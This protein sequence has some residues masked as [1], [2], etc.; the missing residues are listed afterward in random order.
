MDQHTNLAGADR[1]LRLLDLTTNVFEFRT[2]DDNIDRY[3][4]DLTKT[5]RGSLARHAGTLQRLNERGAGVFV[6]V[7]E[8]DGKGR[9]AEHIIRVRTVFVDLDGV[10]LAPV[11]SGYSPP[12]I[13]VETSPER[14]HCYWRVDGM[15]LGDFTPVQLALIR[16]FNS[17]PIIHDLPR[18][19]RL[20]GFVHAKVKN[21]IASE[22]FVSRIIHA[23]DGP[24]YPASHFDKLP[25]E[26]HTPGQQYDVTPLD[27][28]KAAA[29]L[30]VIPNVDLDWGD[31]NR[32]GMATWRSTGGSHYGYEA[33]DRW[34]AKSTLKYNPART[35]KIWKGYHRSPPHSIGCG[36]LV[37]L[38]G[39]ADPGWR[40]RFDAEVL[41]VMSGCGT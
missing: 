23:T 30:E 22:P 39:Q 37:M 34:S 26:I 9:T 11:M 10:P 17:D 35:L 3:D 24:A 7:N 41:A 18:V 13:I 28:W 19:M 25:T 29:A 40:E 16:R 32:V 6:T 14:W 4:P 5:F 2:F 33:F 27:E 38:A 8:T 12:H 20:P 36:T 15:A 21:G 1:F 31:W